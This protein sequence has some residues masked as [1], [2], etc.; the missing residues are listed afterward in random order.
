MIV[1]MDLMN[2]RLKILLALAAL[3]ATGFLAASLL[4][5]YFFPYAKFRAALINE[6][7]TQFH[8][9]IKIGKISWSLVKGLTVD[10][11]AI[12]ESPDFSHGIFA[13]L[14]NSSLLLSWRALL[15]KK[16]V[17]SGITIE[18]LSLRVKKTGPASYNF[19]DLLAAS[20]APS[21]SSA[22]EMPPSK[23]W[24]GKFQIQKIDVLDGSV[25]YDDPLR[26]ARISF[27]K[28][29][30]NSSH[31]EINR[32]FFL[33]LESDFSAKISS[34]AQEAAG[35]FQYLGTVDIK[36]AGDNP[37]TLDFTRF[38]LQSGPYASSFAG[39]I[40]AGQ[41]QVISHVQGRLAYS[42]HSI[43]S[44]NWQGT[45]SAPWTLSEM[46]ANGIISLK[47]P[48]L[49]QSEAQHLFRRCFGTLSL[50]E[51]GTQA[52]T[53]WFKTPLSTIP[54]IAIHGDVLLDRGLISTK[55]MTIVSSSSTLHVS[56]SVN[57]FLS[58][59]PQPNLKLAWS[60]QTPALKGKDVFFTALPPSI[61]IPVLQI[62][63]QASLDRQNLEISSLTLASALGN[64]SVQGTVE[65]IFSKNPKPNLDIASDLKF[66]RLSSQ[67]IAWAHLS[68][69]LVI[70]STHVQA[71]LNLKK[72]LLTFNQA[73]VL[74]H[75]GSLSFSGPVL[76][77]ASRAPKP[78]LMISA[79]INLP[80]FESSDIPF[81][82]LPP[83][84]K[85]PPSRW[86]GSFYLG[87]KTIRVKQIKLSFK[88]NTVELSKSEFLDITGKNPTLNI[89]VKCPS[90]DLPEL[91]PIFPNTRKLKL[92]GH[93]F[94]AL[95]AS[96]P[97]ERPTLEG[98]LKFEDLGIKEL[99]FDLSHFT[100]IV[101]FN[102][103]RI[104]APDIYGKFDGSQTHIDLTVKNYTHRPYID[105]EIDLAE[106]NLDHFF[107]ARDRFVQTISSLKDSSVQTKD[108]LREQEKTA[109]PIDSKGIL[110][111]NHLTHPK[112]RADGVRITWDVQGITPKL[113]TLTGHAHILANHGQLKDLGNLVGQSILVKILASPLIAIQKITSFGGIRLFP[114]FNNITFQELAGDYNFADG[115]M[116][117]NESHVYSD[118]ANVS[119]KGK[120]DIPRENLDMHVIAQVA[121]IAPMKISVKGKFDKPKIH[122][123]LASLL[124]GP[125]KG[126]LNG[127]FG[128]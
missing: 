112:F 41:N 12:S 49:M 117:V 101:S 94:F 34:R 42:G 64:L 71:K 22:R 6:A 83:G 84:I 44:A 88:G 1:I 38:A 23:K 108:S 107:A 58:Q 53:P 114:N 61:P 75:F 37:I 89:L 31:I 13:E 85:F 98:K 18:D 54:P 109:S 57:K 86:D 79:A 93:G 16:I 127:L 17:V 115:I 124:L 95:A 36:T 59:N 76:D 104:D 32:P 62:R 65:N 67:E 105:T 103:Q 30:L 116:A 120:I 26:S 27:S 47:A 9:Q 111:I 96:G 123:D 110:N 14:R 92:V 66:P 46:R 35:K 20:N 50:R 28:I 69:E 63:G 3:A 25:S 60:I 106:F 119:A 72:S 39:Q 52:E 118:A 128:K 19:S 99:G 82:Q 45:L 43:L 113:K 102:D 11:F 56:G 81:H 4:I 24:G 90:F 97:L 55:K 122:V 48:A 78:H 10:D 33:S 100:G 5:A 91:T 70:P 121:N 80:A 7:Q 29:R 125:T 8:R 74:T 51:Q 77:Y 21:N 68:K 2:R 15:H 40:K 73:S 87:Q 126:L